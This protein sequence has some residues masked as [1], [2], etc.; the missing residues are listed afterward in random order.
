MT[1]KS[2]P[3][4][5]DL[6]GMETP[7]KRTNSKPEAAALHEVLLALR[8]HPS[9]C[10]VERMNSGAVKVGTRFIRFGFV[11]CA[12]LIG[13][14]TDGR[15]LACEVKSKTGR[16]SP[17]QTAFLSQINNNGGIGF[18]ARNCAD[19]FRELKQPMGEIS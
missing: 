10:W 9:V 18:V 17:E 19:V 15:F 16:L 11:G 13:M 5:T 6:F 2:L 12:D 7:T 3:G 4:A 8:N 14:L 1:D